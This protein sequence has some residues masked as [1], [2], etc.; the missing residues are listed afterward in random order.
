[1]LNIL[2][3][4]T[5]LII[6]FI[7]MF[8]GFLSNEKPIATPNENIEIVNNTDGVYE[9]GKYVF[10]NYDDFHLYCLMVNQSKEMREYAESLGEDYFE[11]HNLVIVDVVLANTRGKTYFISS[12]ETCDTIDIHYSVVNTSDVWNDVV[13]IDSICVK[14][15]KNI[16]KVTAVE[17][18]APAT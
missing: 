10:D 1:M 16:T 2:Q 5:A 9:G 3:R 14:T 8:F 4:I 7:A 18:P 15:G 13:C 6:S 17:M 12:K 11:E